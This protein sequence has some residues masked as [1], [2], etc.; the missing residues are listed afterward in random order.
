MFQERT[1]T[2]L[3]KRQSVIELFNCRLQSTAGSQK[4][5]FFPPDFPSAII[6][7]FN[8]HYKKCPNHS[9]CCC[10][11]L[12]YNQFPF[13]LHNCFIQLVQCLRCLQHETLPTQENQAQF[14]GSMH[15]TGVGINVK[16]SRKLTCFRF[17]L[18]CVLN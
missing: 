16:V 13:L 3:T 1:G 9:W 11:L 12:A 5:Q 7:N 18:P 17:L 2:L 14:G 15:K 6:Y 10:L 4:E 8:F